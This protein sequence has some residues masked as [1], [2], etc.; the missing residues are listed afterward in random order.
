VAIDGSV[1]FAGK[2]SIFD[3]ANA[4]AKGRITVRG[5]HEE[6]K[7]GP[8]CHSPKRPTMRLPV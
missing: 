6:Q 2:Y 3:P 8:S 5:F 7:V 1:P 4:D